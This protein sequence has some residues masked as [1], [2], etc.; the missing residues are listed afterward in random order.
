MNKTDT[1]QL[2]RTLEAAPGTILGLVLVLAVFAVFS[3]Y[4]RGF[5]KGK[6][7]GLVWT[8]AVAG[9]T[10]LCGWGYYTSYLA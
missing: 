1:S 8:L 5:I 10:L 9:L 3:P 7:A 4:A 2:I 6:L